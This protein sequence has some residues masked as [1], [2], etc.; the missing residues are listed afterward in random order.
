MLSF[1]LSGTIGCVLTTAPDE[2]TPAISS[3]LNRDGAPPRVAWVLCVARDPL[4][5][6]KILQ[7]LREGDLVRIEGEIEERRR[8]VGELAFHSVGFVVCTIERTI[9]L[10]P[11]QPALRTDF[12]PGHHQSRLRRMA[13]RVRRR[14]DDNRVARPAHASLR[15]HRDRQRKLALQDAQL[16]HEGSTHTTAI[17]AAEGVNSARRSGVSFQR[18]LTARSA[19]VR[20]L[21][22]GEDAE[23]RESDRQGEAAQWKHHEPV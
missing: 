9:A 23:G 4:L 12:D 13:Q 3:A 16:I 10:P 17:N 11:D 1:A 20:A 21:P 2:L 15:D 14:Q 8:Q 18:R 7:Q 22:Q 6:T 19:H 5:R